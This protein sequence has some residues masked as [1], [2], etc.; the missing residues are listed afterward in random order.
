MA[1]Q[2]KEVDPQADR[3]IAAVPLPDNDPLYGSNGPL[4]RVWKSRKGAQI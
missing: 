2:P 4:K 3:N 1:Q